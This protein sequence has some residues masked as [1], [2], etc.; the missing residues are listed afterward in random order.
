MVRL[1]RWRTRGTGRC[2]RLFSTCRFVAAILFARD[3]PVP[4]TVGR[5]R[6]R[7]RV[8]VCA[9]APPRVRELRRPAIRQREPSRHERPERTRL[10][11]GPDHGTCEQ[12]ASADVALAPARR[13][14][15]RPR[16]RPA[17]PDERGH[18]PREHAPALRPAPRDDG[19]A[20]PE[21]FRGRPLCGAPAARRVGGLDRGA[22]GRAER[23]AVP[24]HPAG[25]SRVRAAARAEPLR[26]RGR[27]LRA[28]AHGQA[29][30]RHLAVRPPPP[31]L[32]AARSCRVV[33]H[34]APPDRREAAPGGTGRGLQPGHAG[35]P[36]AHRPESRAASAEPAFR[37]RGP[38]LRLVRGQG[39]L[40]LTPRRS[41]SLS[42]G[43]YRVAGARGGRHCRR[44]FLAGVACVPASFL[45]DRR[46]VLVCRDAGARPG[47]RAGGKP[48][49]GGP[50]HVH[51]RHRPL[52]RG[53][54]GSC[55]PRGRVAPSRPPAGGRRGH[56]P[57][58]GRARRAPAS[59]VLAQQ[60]RALG[61]CA[62][63]DGGKLSR[64]EQSG[65]RSGQAGPDRGSRHPLRGISA[66]QA[67]L[68]GSAQQSR[69][70]PGRPG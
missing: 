20:L 9:R 38:R 25:L 57:L 22:Q 53:G 41:L 52:H 27:A 17:P 37:H 68:P 12:L 42:R 55:R 40:P 56:R 39:G 63:C 31:R 35:R 49:L 45:P 69:P 6:R 15:V 32:L 16:P 65:P 48:A 1:P 2:P 33:I 43:R 3:P 34:L 7:R 59:R 14:A 47:P 18:S 10:V 46:L 23:A 62:R 28:G 50:L 51:P 30:A 64:G 11:L 66:H 21:R 26:R 54:V 60:R 44:R 13:R 58:R 70:G 5:P 67:G 19:S 4:S 29:D 36:A 24:A 8:R 61:A